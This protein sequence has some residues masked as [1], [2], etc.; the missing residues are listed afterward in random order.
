MNFLNKYWNLVSKELTSGQSLSPV[1]AVSPSVKFASTSAVP[2][3][4]VDL[5]AGEVVSGECCFESVVVWWWPG[6][7]SSWVVS[8]EECGEFSPWKASISVG[9]SSSDDV[10][11]LWSGESWDS[12]NKGKCSEFHINFGFLIKND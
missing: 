12:T 11:G 2:S 10:F 1:V 8:L 3:I 4:G 5:W 6:L 7:T 9:V